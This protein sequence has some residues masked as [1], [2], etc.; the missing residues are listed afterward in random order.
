MLR[1]CVINFKGNWDGHLPFIE[2]AYNNSYHSSILMALS[3]ALYERIYRSPIG[4]FEVHEARLVG[5]DLVHQAMEISNRIGNVAYELKL[6]SELEVFHSVRRLKTKEVA[7]VQVLW[8]NHFV[9]EASSEAQE[10]MKKTYPHL[11]TSKEITDQ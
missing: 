10:D 6:P 5:P 7:S 4:W 8:R 1:A 3:E 11:F 2:F 9:E